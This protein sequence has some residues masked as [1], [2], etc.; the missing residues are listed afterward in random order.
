[1][2]FYKTNQRVLG[3]FWASS[4]P[5]KKISGTL[6]IL[7]NGEVEITTLDPFEDKLLKIKREPI[8][9]YKQDPN[10]FTKQV[11]TESF[12]YRKNNF[13]Q[14]ALDIQDDKK[15]SKIK[16][17]F[18]NDDEIPEFDWIE[19]KCEFGYFKF[20]SSYKNLSKQK[21]FKYS[22]YNGFDFGVIYKDVI[23]SK[24]DGFDKIRFRIDYLSLFFCK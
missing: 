2:P 16:T 1:M 7:E 19:G 24:Q 3:E 15:I 13:F 23:I 18:N 20:F 10:D 17:K 5:N 12:Y 4:N 11:I 8:K 22:T 9:N 14:I 21:G 6:E